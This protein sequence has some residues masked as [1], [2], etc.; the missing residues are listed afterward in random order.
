MLRI[1]HNVFIKIC[2][3]VFTL[4]LI[5]L[6]SIYASTGLFEYKEVRS[7]IVYAPAV[8]SKGG[9]VLSRVEL[10]LAYP[11]AGRVFFSSLPYTEVETQGAS[12]V[13]AFIASIFTGEDYSKYD[14][15]VLL[16]SNTPLVG[17]PS[18]GGLITVGFIALLLNATIKPNVTMTGMINPDGTIG[19]VGGLKEKLEAV[20][21][22]GFKV[23]LIPA[24]QRFY[25]YPVYVE[26]RIGP[27]VIGRVE[28][29][30][31]DLVDYGRKLGVDVHE[32]SNVAEALFYF[33]G[34]NLTHPRVDVTVKLSSLEKLK[35]FTSSTLSSTRGLVIDATSIASQLGRQ[36]RVI[37]TYLQDINNSIDNLSK[38]TNTYPVY[39]AYKAIQLYS[40]SF[41]L[42]WYARI[43]SGGDPR[44]LLN[45][46]NRTIESHLRKV[47]Q[48]PCTLGSS[49]R[50]AMTYLSWLY[51]LRATN[52]TDPSS[53]INYSSEAIEYLK[54]AELLDHIVNKDV[55]FKSCPADYT[56]IY[57]HA[58]A[59]YTYTERILELTGSTTGVQKHAGDYLTI[60]NY[61]YSNNKTSVYAAASLVIAASARAIH[62]ASRDTQGL[63]SKILPV[64]WYFSESLNN[65][66]ALLYLDLYYEASQSGDIDLA[67]SSILTLMGILSIT[68]VAPGSKIALSTTPPINS[69]TS[70]STN[71]INSPSTSN[72]TQT[73]EYPSQENWGLTLLRPVIIAVVTLLAA[74][75]AIATLKSLRALKKQPVIERL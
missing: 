55:E 8:S 70:T 28:Y 31:V 69:N 43:Y 53:I 26:K 52:T 7:I 68:R 63:P 61:A 15:F 64:V 4:M 59:S 19:P 30:I 44:M 1:N 5:T 73:S 6:A 35:S 42:Y 60:L 74:A 46:V 9:G 72:N 11:G 71:T 17:G 24:G 57:S 13:A 50:Q 66:V 56:V 21:S 10:A 38:F 49:W 25:R 48:A 51:Y 20:S 54:Y 33:T 41:K 29:Q 58:L 27:L 67:T 37:I 75:I 32:V 18:A 12:R 62:D 22:S 34:L 36:G 14:Y 45:Q 65:D 16:E 40:Y 47:D 2:F 3:S 39:T 23:F